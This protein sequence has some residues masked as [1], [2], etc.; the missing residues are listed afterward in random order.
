MAE[1]ETMFE[2]IKRLRAERIE[3][4]KQE[5]EEKKNKNFNT[6]YEQIEWLGLETTEKG[7]LS[8]EKVFR[9]L[10]NIVE[11]KETPFDARIIQWSKIIT[12]KN[13]WKNVYWKQT[14]EGKIDED[15]ILYRLYKAINESNFIKYTEEEKARA[16]E[17]GK[18]YKRT[19]RRGNENGYFENKHVNTPSF[20]RIDKNKKEGKKESSQFY[21]R[22]RVVMNVI[23]RMDDWCKKNKHS[24]VLS[25][26]N[27][28]FEVDDLE[29]PGRKKNIYIYTEMGIPFSLYDLI[30]Q[31]VFEFRGWDIDI[32]VERLQVGEKQ[33]SY[34]IS[35]SE[36]GKVSDIAKKYMVRDRNLSQEEREYKLYDLEKLFHDTYYN[37]LLTSF[38]KLFQQADIDLGT[39]FYPELQELARIEKEE[40]DR[41]K[42]EKEATSIPVDGTKEHESVEDEIREYQEEEER[43]SRTE[44]KVEEEPVRK[45]RDDS[46]TVETLEDKIRKV[47][48]KLDSLEESEQKEVLNSIVDVKEG[49]PIYDDK[50]KLLACKKT[51]QTQINLPDSV[52]KCPKC[53]LDL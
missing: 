19:D 43:Q 44:T 28:A 42:K 34:I 7:G 27:P 48:P 2:K 47:F 21:P 45:R 23:D 1:Q 15:W 51:C 22:K 46:N 32:I 6:D 24:K 35:D 20:I 41:I 10:G 13:T 11:F 36:D 14:S 12:D 17:A 38:T 39:K 52:F 31:R 30:Y 9:V 5:A 37:T 33:T 40:L 4:E 3:K 53:A 26:N 49:M 50:V 8:K 18:D 29:N 25:G 16:K